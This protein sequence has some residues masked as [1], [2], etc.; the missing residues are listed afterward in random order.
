MS[1]SAVNSRCDPVAS[2]PANDTWSPRTSCVSF[3]S[4]P[5]A[6]TAMPNSPCSTVAAIFFTS[7]GATKHACEP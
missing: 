4:P 5:N 1:H 7:D 2:F 3:V 6:S